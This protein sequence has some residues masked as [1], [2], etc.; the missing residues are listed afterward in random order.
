MQKS[1]PE[2]VGHLFPSFDSD[3]LQTRKLA[4]RG[5]LET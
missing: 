2:H 1:K 3:L 5:H 4:M